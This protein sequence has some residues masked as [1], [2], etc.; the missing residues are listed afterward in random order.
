VSSDIDYEAGQTG[1]MEKAEG[2]A[3]ASVTASVEVAVE[4]M[5]AFKIFTEEIDRWWQ[6]GPIT[7]NNPQRAVGVRF[8]P[9]VGGRWLE[10]YDEATGEGFEMG[11]ITVWEPGARLVFTYFDA[12]HDIDGTEVEISFEPVV[13][14]T[15]VTVEHRRWDMADPDAAA[16]KII[17]KRWGWAHILSWYSD[18][19]FMGSP[20]RI[21]RTRGDDSQGSY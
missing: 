16:R 17:T 13:A 1:R 19:A 3:L 21:W 20:H 4:P 12:G 2:M 15:R 14:G 11:R 6:R 5:T 7:W 18:W 10:V 8:E 9:G